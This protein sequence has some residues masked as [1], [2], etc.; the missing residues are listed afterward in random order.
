MLK[1]EEYPARIIALYTYWNLY[2]FLLEGLNITVDLLF[3]LPGITSVCHFKYQRSFVPIS[4]I[5]H[6]YRVRHDEAAL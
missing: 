3:D 2:R 5:E 1:D 4:T 6:A